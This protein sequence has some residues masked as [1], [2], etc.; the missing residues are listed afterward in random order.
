MLSAPFIFAAMP[1]TDRVVAAN[2]GIGAMSVAGVAT[3]VFA[4]LFVGYFIYVGVR[5]WLAIRRE[6]QPAEASDYHTVTLADL[7]PTM[8]DGGE[9]DAKDANADHK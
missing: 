6:R 7:G 2:G 4:A 3:L 1:V 5:E 8:A 9:P